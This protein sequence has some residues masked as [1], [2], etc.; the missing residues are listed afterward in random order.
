L[1]TVKKERERKVKKANHLVEDG[2][3]RSVLAV[4]EGFEPPQ[5]G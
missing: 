4:R 3:L 1:D 5:G 2:L